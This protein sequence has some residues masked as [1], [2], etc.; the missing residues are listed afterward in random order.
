MLIW[1]WRIEILA[2]DEHTVRLVILTSPCFTFQSHP[3]PDRSN[4]DLSIDSTFIITSVNDSWL[5]VHLLKIDA[6]K[7]FKPAA[8]LVEWYVHIV[9]I[10][11]ISVI[12]S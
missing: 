12:M 6:L 8:V 9:A 3:W 7:S 4:S 2:I 5:T 11:Y 1:P 10:D